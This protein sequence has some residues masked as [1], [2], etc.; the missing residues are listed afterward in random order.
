MGGMRR[1]TESNN[2]I[3]G[4]VLVE[5]WRSVAAMAVYNKKPI[6]SSCTSGCMLVEVLYPLET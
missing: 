4:A 3:I 1:H 6:D 5:L 2:L